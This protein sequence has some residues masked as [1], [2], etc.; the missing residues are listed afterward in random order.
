MTSGF[1][2]LTFTTADVSYLRSES[3]AVALAAVAEL[4]LTAAT[5]IADS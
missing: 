2:G 4:E 3:G 1:T 5:R